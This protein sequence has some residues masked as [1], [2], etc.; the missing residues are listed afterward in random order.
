MSAGIEFGKH[1]PC[2]NCKGRGKACIWRNGKRVVYRE[3][4]FASHRW[5]TFACPDCLGIGVIVA[6]PIHS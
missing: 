3:W 4:D 6:R 1:I 5:V 2:P